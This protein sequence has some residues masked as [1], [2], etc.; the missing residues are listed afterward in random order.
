MAISASIV[1]W[2]GAGERAK[3]VVRYRERYPTLYGETVKDGPPGFVAA[4][5]ATAGILR[6]AQNDSSGG[7]VY[8]HVRR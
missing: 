2:G 1:C 3:A 6:V 4:R 7:G 8:S 5:K